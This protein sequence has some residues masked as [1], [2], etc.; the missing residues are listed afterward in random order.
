MKKLKRFIRH[1]LREINTR[2]A[3]PFKKSKEFF[4]IASHGQ[5]ATMWFASALNRHPH[6]FCE[7]GYMYPPEGANGREFTLEEF[8]K[9]SE[10]TA[11]RFW[12]LSIDQYIGELRD[13]TNELF[14][15][16]V[17]A[18]TYG[19][20]A[21]LMDV[22]P[23]SFTDRL[24]ILNMVRHPITRITST[25]KC[26]NPV[27]AEK[28][29]EF[30][31]LS[32]DFET[33]CGHLVEYINKRHQI[34]FTP[35]DKS[36]IVA[37]LS[38]EDIT[39][40]MVRAKQNKVYNICFEKLISDVTYFCNVVRRITGNKLSHASIAELFHTKQV[41]KHNHQ[42][43]R[44]P[45]QQYALWEPWQQDVFQFIVERHNMKEVYAEFDYAFPA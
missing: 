9:R 34:E 39:Q 38:L 25:F 4:I 36:F 20:L 14:A 35:Q 30:V 3:A 28:P 33:R 19:R 31:F 16:S 24:T 40:D 27:D 42:Q 17:H 44:T 12:D 13:C 8:K 15:G 43:E 22:A 32:K 1:T 41:N 10:V 21:N 29:S 7:H 5:T 26:W 11:S 6:I 37:I 23:I 45:E 18:F 2:I